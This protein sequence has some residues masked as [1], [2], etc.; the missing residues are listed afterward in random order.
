LGVGSLSL[1]AATLLI[2]IGAAP[3]GGGPADT[4]LRVV[5]GTTET[6]HAT[7]QWLAML[8]RRL[9]PERYAAIAPLRKARTVD[10]QAWA[11]LIHASAAAWE[12]M[13][14]ALAELFHPVLPPGDVMIVLGNRGAE[15]AFTHDPTTIGFDLAALQANYGDAGL[16][17]NAER[18][19]RFFRHEFVH[20][21]QKAWLPRHPWAMDSPLR[22]ALAEIWAEGL[23]NYHSLSARWLSTD[24]KRSKAAASAL[25]TLEPR[26]VARLAALACTTPEAAEA[27]RADLSQGPF[28]HKWGALP[29]ALWLEAEPGAPTK[30]L[31]R[32]VVAGPGGVWDLADRHLP[33]GLG[34]ALREVRV[35]DSLCASRRDSRGLSQTHAQ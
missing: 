3:V 5:S 7:E 35:A 10:E 17:E 22:T 24:G 23:G 6:G 16:P 27:L 21:L 25:A 19:N 34:S 12:E 26:F 31:R 32:F 9:P 33:A 11:R 15:D 30:A 1:S 2:L 18:I 13:V 4:S 8:R 29:A 28:D 20:L 14:P